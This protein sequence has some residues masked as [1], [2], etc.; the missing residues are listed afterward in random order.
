MTYTYK[1]ALEV[2]GEYNAKLFLIMSKLVKKHPE[3]RFGQILYNFSF[4][5]KP[6]KEGEAPKLFDPFNEEPVVTFHRV[7]KDL[8]KWGY[9]DILKLVK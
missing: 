1:E 6:L 5:T 7:C 2:R 4:I 3:L 9:T 8:E